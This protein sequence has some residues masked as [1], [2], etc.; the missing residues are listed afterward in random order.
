MNDIEV[1]SVFFYVNQ[2]EY[3]SSVIPHGLGICDIVICE[4][5][6]IFGL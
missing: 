1:F 3:R 5:K 2:T 6:Y 4:K